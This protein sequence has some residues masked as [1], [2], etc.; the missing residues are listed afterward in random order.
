M[1]N[2]LICFKKLQLIHIRFDRFHNVNFI[3]SIHFSNDL[4]YLWSITYYS[5]VHCYI[6]KFN[7]TFL[8]FYLILGSLT[9]ASLRYLRTQRTLGHIRLLKLGFTSTNIIFLTKS[10]LSINGRYLFNKSCWTFSFYLYF[11]YRFTFI[12]I[13]R[14]NL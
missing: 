14:K 5:Y 13:V 4:E 8:L 12:L 11:I 6:F 2:R 1:R 3:Y 10:S 9:N 7:F